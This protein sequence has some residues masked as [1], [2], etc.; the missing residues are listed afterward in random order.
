MTPTSDYQVIYRSVDVYRKLILEAGISDADVRG[1]P[2]YTS[3]V[4]TEEMVDLRR[5]LMPFLPEQSLTLG[6]LTWGVLR[7][8]APLSF[9]TSP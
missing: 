9:G 5:K 1:N 8:T 4:I 2:G 3:M 6:S 7:A